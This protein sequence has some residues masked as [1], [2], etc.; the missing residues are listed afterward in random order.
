M[1]KN[2]MNGKQKGKAMKIAVASDGDNVTHHFGHCKFFL[3]FDTENGAITDTK[4]LDNP[5][6]RPGFLPVF[7][8]EKGAEVI[9]SGGMGAGAVDL[10][11]SNGIDVILGASGYAKD[12][13]EKY[14][15][16]DLVSTGSVCHEHMHH[17]DCGE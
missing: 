13:V 11:D 5:G 3:M 17:D 9:I 14:L 6:H 12:A 1:D 10:F 4:A 7:L 2:E 8:K 16:G 15:K